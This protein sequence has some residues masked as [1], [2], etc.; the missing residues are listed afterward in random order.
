V[1]KIGDGVSE[2]AD[3]EIAD[4][5][6]ASCFGGVVKF[7]RRGKIR[8]SAGIILLRPIG[9]A[10]ID[11]SLIA[12]VVISRSAGFDDRSAGVDPLGGIGALLLVH[13]SVC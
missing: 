2:I 9:F 12:T 1:A 4:A 7:E 5:A 13:S 11:E 3:G 8:N 10:A 6:I